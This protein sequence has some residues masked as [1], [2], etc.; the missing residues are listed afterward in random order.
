MSM[1]VPVLEEGQRQILLLA[2]AELALSRPGFDYALSEIAKLY[3]GEGL[4]MFQDFKLINA[5]RV[6]AERGPLGPMIAQNDD[7]EL[8]EWLANAEQRGGGFVS[9]IAGAALRADDGNYPLIRPL[10]VQLRAKYT[11]YEPT[12]DVKAEIRSRV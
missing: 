5:D 10:M 7:P 4:P 8:L 1:P 11:E 12:E 3:D 2:L 6:N 9:R